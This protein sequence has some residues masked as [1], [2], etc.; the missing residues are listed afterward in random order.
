MLGHSPY[1]YKTIR[2]ALTAFGNIFKDL[3]MIKYTNDWTFTEVS[4]VGVPLS[5]SG[6]EGFI[7]RLQDNPNLAKGVEITLPR[8]SF[9]LDPDI[10]Y[11]P[12]RKM[13]TFLSNFSG[14]SGS[15]VNQQY[16]GVP[17]DLKVHLYIY[18]RNAEDG[19]QLVEQIM[20][21]FTPDY[22]VSLDLIPEMGIVQNMPIVLD[23]VEQNV[24]YEGDAK[25]TERIIV[26]HMMFTLPL[27]FY[28][29]ISS[30]GL[31]TSTNTNSIYDADG[32][33]SLMEAF[34]QIPG[35]GEY[36]Q[37]EVVYQGPNLPDSTIQGTV[38]NWNNTAG[39]MVLTNITGQFVPNANVHGVNSGASW[40]I[41]TTT[42]DVLLAQ[43][44]ETVV[45]NTANGSGDYLVIDT[46]TEYPN[47]V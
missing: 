19:F 13:S 18:V 6:K 17:Y 41:N 20:P 29:P 32:G 12:D 7:V 31:I 21:F 3:I 22:T 15:S 26:W 35:F 27:N 44:R 2:K 16:Q 8:M 39:R 36:Q 33:G 46:V 5:Y 30:G 11:N 23:S 43:I 42:P 28:G 1:Y 14:T 37:G 47:T 25:T 24:S 10:R 4:R 40:I 9:E 34:F 38:Y 45:P